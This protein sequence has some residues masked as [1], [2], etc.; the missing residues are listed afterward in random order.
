MDRPALV[1]DLDEMAGKWPLD[2]AE[3]LADLALRCLSS[4]RGPKTDLRLATVVE[5]LNDLRGIAADL[6]ARGE[7]EVTNDKGSDV[8]TDKAVYG[9]DPTDVPSYFLCPIFQ[10]CFAFD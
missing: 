8:A 2:L 4:N 1:R 10:V 3:R 9:E 6:V 5:E 7:C